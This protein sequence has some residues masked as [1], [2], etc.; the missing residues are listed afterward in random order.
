MQKVIIASTNPV[1]INAVKAGFAK[2]LPGQEFTFMGLQF[3]SPVNAQPFGDDEMLQGAILRTEKARELAPGGDFWVGIE[4]GVDGNKE[5]MQAFAWV[6]V[7]SRKQQ[8]QARSASFFLP[9]QIADLVM[10][11][12]ELGEADDIVFGRTNSK[13]QNGAVGILTRDAV[14]RQQLYE[15]PVMLALIPFVNPKLY[16]LQKPSAS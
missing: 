9:K 11:G 15:Q 1:K 5:N 12:K 7:I 3:P 16:P 4:G 8:G 2:M 10:D 6:V 13:Q 14:D